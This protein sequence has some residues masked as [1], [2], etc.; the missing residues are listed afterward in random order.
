MCY[1]HGLK[2]K[3]LDKEFLELTSVKFDYAYDDLESYIITSFEEAKHTISLI[4]RYELKNM[5]ILEFGS[6]LGIAS[7]LLHLKG[8]NIKSFEPGGLGFEKNTLINRHILAHLGLEIKVFED[9]NDIDH[10]SFNLIFSNN[11][12]EHIDNVEDVLYRLNNILSHNGIMLHNLPNYIFPYEPHFGVFFIPIYPKKM[13]FIINSNI[14][15]TNV[16]ISLNFINAF[17]IKKF[18]KNMNA[19]ITFDNMTMYHS[20]IRLKQ[21]IEFQKR[22]SRIY[23]IIMLIQKLGAL[24]LLKFLPFYLSTPMVFEWKKN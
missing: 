5:S 14:T 19:K 12:L 1:L 16:W 23:R 3:L 9:L 24:K 2:S 8:Y 17:D 4:N 13:S 22:H 15:S 18:A 6:G 10:G 11:V 20:V 7:I 21:D